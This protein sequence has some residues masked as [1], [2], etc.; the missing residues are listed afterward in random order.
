MSRTINAVAAALSL[1]IPLGQPLVVWVTPAVGIWSELVSTQAAYAQSSKDIYRSGLAKYES[2]DYLGAIADFSKV[3]ELDPQ[4]REGGLV[5]AYSRRGLAK[6]NLDNYEGAIS[7]YTK[8]IKFDPQYAAP[9]NFRADAKS[10]L[11]DLQGS[12][13][14]LNRV[15]ELEPGNAIAYRRRGIRKEKLGDLAGACTDWRK[16]AELRDRAPVADWVRKQC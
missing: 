6:E 15:I 1:L 4:N 8:A 10:K 9:Y 12:I 14:D 2:G 3:I 11:G 16:A 5:F 7:D 13:T